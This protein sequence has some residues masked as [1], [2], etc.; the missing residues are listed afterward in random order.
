[1][2]RWAR[3]I[4]SHALNVLSVRDSFVANN[5]PA[6]TRY[7]QRVEVPHGCGVEHKM[8]FRL[9]ARELRD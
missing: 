7:W 5:F 2:A 8:L 9:R 6:I 3:S 4:R 1:M